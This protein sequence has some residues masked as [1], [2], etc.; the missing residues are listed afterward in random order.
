M[1][2]KR[3]KQENGKIKCIHEAKQNVDLCKIIGRRT[4]LACLGYSTYA[5]AIKAIEKNT[6]TSHAWLKIIELGGVGLALLLKYMSAH[7]HGPTASLLEF[8]FNC[9]Q[10]KKEKQSLKKMLL[11]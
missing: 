5:T 10:T 11:T 2:D 7:V 4:V 1:P 6:N 9:N 8:V 3:Y